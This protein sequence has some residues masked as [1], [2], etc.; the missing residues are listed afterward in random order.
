[1]RITLTILTFILVQVIYG[2]TENHFNKGFYTGYGETLDEAG[3]GAYKS[4]ADPRKCQQTKI[5]NSSI[6][7]NVDEKL[8]ADGYR[9]G[10][11]QASKD[12]PLIEKSKFKS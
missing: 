3:Y 8:Y 9:C 12:I 7:K 1:M 6:E 2:Q 5:Y 10:V 11:Q 4:Y